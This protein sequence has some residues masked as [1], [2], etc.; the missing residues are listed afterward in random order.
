MAAISSGMATSPRGSLEGAPLLS[1]VEDGGSL[2]IPELPPKKKKPWILLCVLV[3]FLIACVDVGAYLAE[4]PK[5][6]VYEANLCIRYYEK[7]DPSKI[8]PDG[9]VVEELCKIDT[10]QQKMASIFGWQETFDAIPSILLALPYGALA[11]KKGR[12]W[13]F[14]AALVGLQLNSTWILL[15]CTFFMERKARRE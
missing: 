14:V 13:V 3:F 9:S 5:T 7:H 15:I 12:K 10:V 2:P 11:D 1:P 6:R 8:G 4:A